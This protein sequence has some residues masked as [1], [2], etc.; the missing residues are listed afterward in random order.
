MK[1]HAYAEECAWAQHMQMGS[2]GI[3]IHAVPYS[4]RCI[5]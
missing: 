1:L 2:K 5:E 3:S 4:V